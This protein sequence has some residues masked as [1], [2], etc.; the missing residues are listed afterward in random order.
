MLT[1]YSINVN[2]TRKIFC[3]LEKMCIR[4]TPSSK[5]YMITGDIDVRVWRLHMARPAAGL[6]AARVGEARDGSPLVRPL[7]CVL[8]RVAASRARRLPAKPHIRMAG[9]ASGHT[10][11]D[12]EPGTAAGGGARA[13][14]CAALCALFPWPCSSIAANEGHLTQTRCFPR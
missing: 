3:I 12:K 10:R 8:R 14:A 1:M 2:L 5:P 11:G 6:Q 9:V 13:P 4:Y 7:A